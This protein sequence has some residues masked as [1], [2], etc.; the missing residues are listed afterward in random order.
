MAAKFKLKDAHLRMLCFNF[1]YVFS[2]SIAY[3]T[4]SIK[5]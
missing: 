1:P 3:A 2:I 4:K 5:L